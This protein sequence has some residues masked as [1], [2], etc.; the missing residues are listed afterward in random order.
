MNKLNL[1]WVSETIGDDYEY[2]KPGDTVLIQAQTMTGKTWFIQNVLL[3]QMSSHERLLLVCNRTQLKRQMKRD[4]L[5]RYQ[6]PIPETI[7]EL[8]KITT[9]NNKITITSYHAISN[10]IHNQMYGNGKSD[11]NSYDYIVFD[12]CHFIFSD[13]SFN[14]KT[15]LA[16]KKAIMDSY[17]NK[18]KIFISATMQEVRE[19]IIKYVDRA[20]NNGFGN[21]HIRVHD[22]S[23]GTDYS[24]FSSYYFKKIDNIINMIKNDKSDDKW[25]IFISDLRDGNQILESLG[26]EKCSLIKS[27]TNSEEL[28]SIINESK[29]NK[30][31]LVSTKVLDNGINLFDS[32]LKNIVIMA[33]DQITFLQMLGRKRIN[34]EK[35]EQ[36]NLYIPLRYKK[37]FSTK[38]R[39][40]NKKLDEVKL[41]RNNK[42]EFNRKYDLDLKKFNEINELFYRFHKTGEY[43]VNPIGKLRLEADNKFFAKMVNKY[44]SEGEFAFVKEQLEWMELE[45]TFNKN[46][47]IEEVFIEDEVKTVEDYLDN[48]VDKPLHKQEQ[49]ELKLFITK[50]F[51]EMITKLQGRHK[52]EP[53]LKILNKLLVVCDIPYII[54]SEQ[55]VKKLDGKSKKFTFWTVN[56]L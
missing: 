55:Q 33:W 16:F 7:E 11:F 45:D 53:G 18:V 56:K 2:W 43:R 13:S 3:D 47:L 32:K 17:H 14:N 10:S 6:L 20:K 44:E 31:V 30:K 40:N 4:L 27:G 22:Y 50:D 41:F 15:H 46:N 36:V 49:N 48:L 52:R 1:K 8:D 38:V 19:S 39:K 21:D 42:Q 12:E 25:L 5:K 37:S 28:N 34:I 35:P 29:F 24:Y 51:D 54:K 26:E 23:T 9:I